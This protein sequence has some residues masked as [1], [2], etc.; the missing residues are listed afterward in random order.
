MNR[1]NLSYLSIAVIIILVAIIGSIVYV[2]L[3]HSYNIV[4]LDSFT[5]IDAIYPI[6]NNAVI[7]GGYQEIGNYSYGVAGIYYFSNNSFLQFN[8]GNDFSNG[9][10]YSIASNG[11][12][13]LLAGGKYIG[14]TLVP[15]VFLYHNGISYNYSKFLSNFVPGQALSASWFNN[16]WFIGGDFVY[17]NSNQSEQIMFLV[18]IH[19]NNSID[20]TENIT[21]E[22]DQVPLGSIYTLDS[23]NNELFIGG[24]FAIY[25]SA[26]ILNNN[27]L[28][29]NVSNVFY[30]T[31]GVIFSAS[32]YN[33]NWIA[34]G[35]YFTPQS[36]ES[37]NP[38]PVPYLVEISG[39]NNVSQISLKYQIGIITAV[40]SNNNNVGLVIRV[41]FQNSENIYAGSVVM[42]GKLSSLKSVYQA[43]NVSINN[44]VFLGNKLVGSGYLLTGNN[45]IGIIF[46][47]KV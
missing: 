28:N 17:L 11:S 38:Y 36:I 31:P 29:V 43:N 40:A 21:R 4:K 37:S 35:E 42:V 41:P 32:Y 13:I 5:K 24:T 23:S 19:N 20:L 8:L 6:S 1:K 33:G 27:G 30:R 25:T 14:D 15:S 44:L 3:N 18:S 46:I 39:D 45:S 34:G 2:N 26:F 16:S 12:W 9:V 7:L 10:I 22:L 47:Y